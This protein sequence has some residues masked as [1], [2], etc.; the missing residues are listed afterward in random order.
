[1]EPLVLTDAMNPICVGHR[2]SVVAVDHRLDAAT[3]C[4]S[5]TESVR[6]KAAGAAANVSARLVASRE[7]AKGCV[8]C[9]GCSFENFQGAT[10]CAICGDALV[11]SEAEAAARPRVADTAVTPRQRR[12]R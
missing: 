6:R 5:L 8:V 3:R 12:A 2:L 7:A 11:E 9:A 10:H 4:V 1:M